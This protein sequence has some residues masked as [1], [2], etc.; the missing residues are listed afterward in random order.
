M[1]LT[2]E[3]AALRDR[4]V[5]LEYNGCA[6]IIKAT[7]IWVGR[8]NFRNTGTNFSSDADGAAIQSSFT[9]AG[10]HLGATNITPKTN[11]GMEMEMTV[12]PAGI[13]SESGI[14]FDITRQEQTKAW[15]IDGTNVTEII[16]ANMHPDF[17]AKDEEPNDD[18]GVSDEDNIPNNNHIYSIDFPGT[19]S[20]VAFADRLVIRFNFNEFVRV[21]VNGGAFANTEHVIEGSRCSDKSAWR[22][23]MD[24]IKDTAT[25]KWKRNT[26][27]AGE[28]EIEL[29]H[30]AIGGTPTP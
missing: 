26:V 22:S 5:R 30:K 16:Q 28:N 23:R 20:D 29:G 18:E 4:E 13:G 1:E 9:A 8:T 11:N 3:S 19:Q 14:V 7:G 27:V 17:P 25:G 12:H 6:D 24:V 15:R 10:G 21:L 2:A